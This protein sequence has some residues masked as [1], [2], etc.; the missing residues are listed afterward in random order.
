MTDTTDAPPAPPDADPLAGERD[1]FAEEVLRHA[2]F[3]GW[4]ERAFATAEQAL[5]EPAG[6]GAM[7]FPRGPV[8][9]IEHV[10]ARAD[11][12]MLAEM[13]GH[14]LDAMKV[15]DRIAL[16]VRVRLA[17]NAADKEA[18]RRALRLLALPQNAPTATRLLYRTVD[19]IWHMAGD[20]ATDWNFYS[21]RALLAGV[22]SSTLLHWL[23]DR[24]EGDSAS[25]DFLERRLSDVMGLGRLG[26]KLRSGMRILPNP[27]RMAEAARDS[28]RRAGRR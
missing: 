17:A 8:E 16:G 15:R 23:N 18:I 10:N 13:A 26:G 21:K 1:A 24:S 9:I 6:H 3:D 11:E 2:P 12:A 22:Y 7:L 20:T 14:D 5:G 25:W 28:W 4:T 19:T 27:V